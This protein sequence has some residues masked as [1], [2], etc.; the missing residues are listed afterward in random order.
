[1]RL[2][3]NPDLVAA[4]MDGDIVMMSVETG[5]YFGLTGIAPQ[6]WEALETPLT[7][8]DLLG[9]MFSLYEVEDEVLRADLTTFVADMQKNGLILPA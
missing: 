8:E 7:F 4:E 2:K 1:M 5:S 9:K 3:R 6:I